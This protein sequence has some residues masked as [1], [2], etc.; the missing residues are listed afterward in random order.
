[1]KKNEVLCLTADNLDSDLA[2]VCRYEG[3]PVFVPGL[4]PGE[5]AHVKIVKTEKRFAF[6]R[7][8]APPEEKCNAR[9]IPDC[10]AYPRCGGCTGR[11]MTYEATLEAKRR[12]VQ[13]CFQRIAGISIEVPGP[14][15]MEHPFGYRNKT[16]LP[17]GGTAENPVLGFFAPRSHA[18][19]PVSRCPNAMSPANE[20]AAVFLQWIRQYRL[21]PYQEESHH[22][23][24][25]HLIIRVNRRG[26]SM[27]TVV[28]NGQPPA[29]VRQL[30]QSLI[31]LNTVSVYWNENRDRTNVILSDRF[32]LLSGRKTLSDTLCGLTFELSPASFFQVNPLQTEKLYAEALTMAS[33][34]PTETLCDVY[35][36]VGTMTLMMAP[37]CRRAL[38]IEVVS[39]AV[40]NAASNAKVN[41][42]ENAEF[43]AG[44]AEAV[45]P[46]LVEDGFRPDAIVVDPPRKG[47]DPAVIRAIA[48]AAPSRVIYVSCN[49]ATL[50]RDAGLF[51]ENGF[52]VNRVQPVD[53]FAWS[54][55]IET[56]C[57]LSKHK[58]R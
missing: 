32:L 20:I 16:S 54:S 14:L 35:C 39:A 4:L 22:G 27:V 47:L 36:G 43:L 2:G 8:E 17:V 58:A 46:R 21:P 9:R 24:L 10:D 11:H 51:R 29:C 53:M 57:L 37:H 3:V 30:I 33:L 48:H 56:A 1:M 15:G 45:L 41:R 5:T 19:I 6:G 12:Q 40:E 13:D 28:G 23:L 55:G 50:A 38:G 42:I 25:R 26:E 49:P 31:P 7:M 18:V 34:K 52:M 44:A